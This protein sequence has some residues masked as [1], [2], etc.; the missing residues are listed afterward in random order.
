M[1]WFSIA[2]ATRG[3]ADQPTERFAEA[4]VGLVA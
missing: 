1:D 3:R 2:G 4:A